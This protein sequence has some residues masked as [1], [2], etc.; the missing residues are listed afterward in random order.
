MKKFLTFTI[1]FVLILKG[2]SQNQ[3]PKEIEEE[4]ASVRIP[5]SQSN[6][7]QVKSIT[8]NLKGVSKNNQGALKDE[9][10]TYKDKVITLIYNEDQESM[11]LVYKS[12]IPYS[13]ILHILNNHGVSSSAVLQNE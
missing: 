8:L 13:K 2:Y 1:F 6:S 10:T 9:F 3:T 7:D 11:V 12:I 4:I 5:M